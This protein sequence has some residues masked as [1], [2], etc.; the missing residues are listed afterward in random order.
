MVR[1]VNSCH[2]RR[3][4][5]IYLVWQGRRLMR[6][7]VEQGWQISRARF[8]QV[9]REICEACPNENV[10]TSTFCQQRSVIADTL[11]TAVIFVSELEHV[12]RSRSPGRPTN[13]PKR[14]GFWKIFI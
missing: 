4:L 7:P 10:Q 1:I 8:V 2:R 11:I 13:R 5:F 12:V 3:L 9:L 14:E 6:F